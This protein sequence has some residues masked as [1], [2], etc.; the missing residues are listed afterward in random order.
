[1]VKDGKFGKILIDSLFTVVRRDKTVKLRVPL[2]DDLQEQAKSY[3]ASVL[4]YYRNCLVHDGSR[5]NKNSTLRIL[6]LA[7]DR[8]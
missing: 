3:F 4:A 2:G 7:S 5:I 1:M 8:I 6:V